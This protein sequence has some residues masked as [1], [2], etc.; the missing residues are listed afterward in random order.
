MFRYSGVR[1]DPGEIR[2]FNPETSQAMSVRARRRT[3]HYRLRAHRQTVPAR[4]GHAAR[5]P[6][7]AFA[8]R[9]SVA[10]L[11]ISSQRPASPAGFLL[12]SAAGRCNPFQ[13]TSLY[14]LIHH[15]G[16]SVGVWLR[17]AAR[18]SATRSRGCSP[19]SAARS[20]RPRSRPSDDPRTRRATGILTNG[21]EHLRPTP[22]SATRPD[23]TYLRSLHRLSALATRSPDP[24]QAVFDVAVRHLFGS[25]RR[26][27]DI[28][29]HEI[30]LVP[31]YM[32]CAEIFGTRCCR[33]F[34][35]LSAPSYS[36]D[37]L[38]PP[39]CDACYVLAPVPTSWDNGLG[40][41]AG[42]YRDMIM[43]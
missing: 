16:K 41:Q 17:W 13:T 10:G 38:A 18:R 34:F 30:L 1:G 28:G 42:P 5:G 9:R 15:P 22:W 7:S 20:L 25:D 12:S 19:T 35:A 2:R 36:D 27:D 29:H 4:A 37:L 32:S 40:N 31:L 14:S 26:Y 33:R 43:L 21:G 24:P 23:N 8:V 3:S 39:V 6:S 11:S